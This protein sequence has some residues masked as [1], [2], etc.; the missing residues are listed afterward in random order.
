MQKPRGEINFIKIIEVKIIIKGRFYKNIMDMY[1]KSECMPI[2]WKNNYERDV[3]KRRYLYSK[4]V[5]R[6]EKHYCHFNKR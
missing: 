5:K 1:F 6:K 3:N 4:H 2:L